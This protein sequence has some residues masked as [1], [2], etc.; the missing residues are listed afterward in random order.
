MTRDFFGLLISFKIFHYIQSMNV[1]VRD[2]MKAICA[3]ISSHHKSAAL[4]ALLRPRRAPS[5]R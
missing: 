4:T 3:L 1:D 2:D 5:V